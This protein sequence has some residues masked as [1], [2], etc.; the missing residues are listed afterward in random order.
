MVRALENDL[1]TQV[2]ELFGKVAHAETRRCGEYVARHYLRDTDENPG[3]ALSRAKRANKPIHGS[4][5][6]QRMVLM[7]SAILLGGSASPRA[8]FFLPDGPA[9]HRRE[10]HFAF[11]PPH[12]LIGEKSARGRSLRRCRIV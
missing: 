10:A 12:C 5:G 11:S 9:G 3:T 4:A 7:K 1:L 2:V 6:N 8:K